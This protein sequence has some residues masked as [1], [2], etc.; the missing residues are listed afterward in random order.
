MN[1]GLA[2]PEVDMLPSEPTRQNSELFHIDRKL[3]ITYSE[4]TAV[5][6]GDLKFRELHIFND[7]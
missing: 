5:A 7:N 1:P 2:E 6:V 4:Y 3:L